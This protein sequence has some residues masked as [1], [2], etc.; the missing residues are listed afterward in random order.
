MAKTTKK[1][2]D[3]HRSFLVREFACF[4]TPMQ[5]AEALTAADPTPVQAIRLELPLTE[6]ELP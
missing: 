5:A 4:S 6:R 3:Y 1:L 2:N